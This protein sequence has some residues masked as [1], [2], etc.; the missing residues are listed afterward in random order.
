MVTALRHIEAQQFTVPLATVPEGIADGA[1]MLNRDLSLLEFFRRVLDEAADRSQPVLERL[2]FLAIFSSNIDEFFMIRVSGLMEKLGHISEVPLDGFTILELL[3]EIK[4]RVTAMTDEQMRILRDELLPTLAENA[5]VLTRYRDLSGQ[6]RSEADRYFKEK[7]YPTLTPQAVDP[8]HPFPYISGGS[9]NVALTVR[10]EMNKRVARAHKVTGSEFFVRVKIPSFIP[11]FVPISEP[12]GRFILI[13]DLL[14]A[15]IKLFAPKA[16]PDSCYQFRITR[17]ADIEIREAEAQDLL[18]T[19]EQNLKQRRFGDVVRLEVSADM[20]GEMV[21]YLTQ[22]LEI[23]EDEVYP[24]DGP[25]NLIDAFSITSLNRPDLK[26]PELKVSRPAVV[27]TGESLFDIIRRQDVLLHHPYMPYSIITDFLREAAEDPDV[28]AIKMCLYRIGADSP[29]APL[30]IE[31]SEKGKQVTALIEIKARFDEA[32][33]IEWGKKLELSGVHVVYGLLGLKT[34]AKTTLIVRREGDG[35]RRYVHLAT[36]NYNPATSTVYTDLGLLT[37]DER[38]GADVTDLFNYLTVY[39]QPDEFSKILVAPVNLR[40]K[41]IEMIEREA[42]NAR[43]GKPARI[44]AKINRLADGEI[45]RALYAAS[46]AGVE[47]DLIIRGV[48]TLRPGVHG[49]SDNIRVRSIVGRLLEHSRVYYFENGGDPEVYTGSSDWMPRNLDRRVE[50]IAPIRNKHLRKFLAEVYLARYLKDNV[51]AWE[52]ASD[53]IYRRV[54]R[55]EDEEEFSAQLSF[56][57]DVNIVNVNRIPFE[58]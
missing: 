46:A 51:R 22:S 7:V 27:D 10:P 53:G 15:N 56:Q 2:K 24:I 26:D 4:T 36:G 45:A 12:E 48:C 19:M 29:I 13:E 50:V 32:N 25:M 33:N 42:E 11:R 49:M 35:L 31:A 18:R 1:M 47:I 57:D 5:I 14:S 39:S 38:I 8:S 54:Q 17:D 30:L 6:E 58:I 16:E 43:G 3:A 28:L 52:L 40:E 41:M 23:T 37:S 55:A 34:H 9:I 20:P 44:I 21:A